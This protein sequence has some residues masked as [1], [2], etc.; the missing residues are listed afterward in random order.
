MG[1]DTKQAI[2]ESGA[3]SSKLVFTYSVIEGD[4]DTNGVGIEANSLSLD[5]GMI[6]GESGDAALLGHERLEDD[7]LHQADGIRPELAA[8]KEASVK[9]DTL[10]LTFAE[11]LDGS[12]TPEAEDFRV[13]VEGK[14]RDVSKVSGGREHGEAESG[15]GCQSRRVGDGELRRR[16]GSRSTTDPG[17][18]G[19][20]RLRIHGTDGDEP[21]RQQRGSSRR[22]DSIEDGT[23][24]RS[25][26]CEKG[27]ADS[28][29]AK[30]ELP[31]SERRSGDA[32]APNHCSAQGHRGHGCS[33]RTGGR[34][35]F[36]RM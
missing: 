35:T 27:G 29:T 10:M 17:R 5:G 25:A 12:L 2:Y 20:R 23:A 8:G 21:D 33:P 11:A 15:F 24:D 1:E 32:G 30:G 26:A 14:D 28:F 3:V 36:G 16:H 34:S 22:D 9:K 19:Q 31:A 6:R 4:E 7:P 18:G 13:E